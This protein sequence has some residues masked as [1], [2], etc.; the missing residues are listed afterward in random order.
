M[1]N[2]KAEIEFISGASGLNISLNHL[3]KPSPLGKVGNMSENLF[4]IPPRWEPFSKYI[5]HPD[6]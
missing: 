2:N 4:L 3:A 1:S 5:L 6:S